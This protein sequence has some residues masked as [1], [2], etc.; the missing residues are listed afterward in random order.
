MSQEAKTGAKPLY[1]DIAERTQG[2]LY[3]GVVGPVALLNVKETLPKDLQGL[4]SSLLPEFPPAAGELFPCHNPAA[5]RGCTFQRNCGMIK[6]EKA[7]K[8]RKRGMHIVY[9][10]GL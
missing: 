2:E 10:T 7:R 1:R 8:G 6:T 4:V 5:K 9:G 3:I